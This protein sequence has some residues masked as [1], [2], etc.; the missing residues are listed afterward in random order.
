MYTFIHI[1]ILF[2]DLTDKQLH[3][4]SKLFFISVS[5]QAK[6][7]IIVINLL[8]LSNHSCFPPILKLSLIHISQEHAL[9]DE[10][11]TAPL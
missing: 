4:F 3:L 8:V 6:L 10:F 11:S 2:F 7:Q 5:N 9:Q 1:C